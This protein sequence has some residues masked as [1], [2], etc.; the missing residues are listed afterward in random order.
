M[1]KKKHIMSPPTSGSKAA[2]N[3]KKRDKKKSKKQTVSDLDRQP[4]LDTNDSLTV[5][6]KLN[7]TYS[8]NGTTNSKESRITEL[9]PLSGEAS[10]TA[11]CLPT[12]PIDD[13]KVELGNTTAS[14]VTPLSGESSVMA[15]SLPAPPIVGNNTS[16][17]SYAKK[18]DSSTTDSNERE[19]VSKS[20]HEA[21]GVLA[22]TTVGSAS[23]A[24]EFN[25]IGSTTAKSNAS[26]PL[27]KTFPLSNNVQSCIQSVVASRSINPDNIVRTIFKNIQ[28][29]DY[30]ERAK[31]P[32]EMNTKNT[33]I[34]S[35]TY[36]HDTKKS[37]KK[38]TAGV[39][40]TIGGTGTVSTGATKA[41][42]AAAASSKQTKLSEAVQH[43]IKS[44]VKTPS[45][46]LG[47]SE[48]LKRPEPAVGA[49]AQP[50]MPSSAK[51][52]DV[53]KKD[54]PIKGRSYER[55]PVVRSKKNKDCI[56][57]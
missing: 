6:D 25:N 9:S 11:S 56:I 34:S 43:C 4:G 14:E 13:T 44:V 23:A 40:A 10:L 52:P 31:L 37:I 24:A 2:K 5:T 47:S 51:A 22:A 1:E 29:G 3:K 17:D 27:P 12:A 33:V 45:V 30:K 20:T 57:V 21:G 19:P 38:A 8:N 26:A 15:A 48:T 16:V 18:M 41:N 49:P 39:G 55:K 46:N 42:G 54:I 53:P 7:P 50:V 28:L 35:T 32:D 36:E